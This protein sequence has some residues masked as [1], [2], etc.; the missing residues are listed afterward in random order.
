MF[1]KYEN[2][3]RKRW[4]IRLV[5]S[6]AAATL[7][8]FG[9]TALYGRFHNATN[10]TSGLDTEAQASLV[11]QAPQAPSPS[12]PVLTNE[13]PSQTPLSGVTSDQT[14]QEPAN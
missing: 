11:Q 10:T 8:I 13:Q 12:A 2:S 5:T 7:L 6:L 3:Q 14:A 1:G 4:L 9:G